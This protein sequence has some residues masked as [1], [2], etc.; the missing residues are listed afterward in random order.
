MSRKLFSTVTLK[1]F[2]LAFMLAL[3]WQVNSQGVKTT[4]PSMAPVNQYLMPDKNSE[5]ALAA[6]AAPDSI[7]RDAEVLVLTQHGYETAV[8]GT[9]GFG[10]SR[11]CGWTAPLDLPNV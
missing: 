6:S 9:N 1:I 5:I 7:S 3:A 11:E 4:Y 10:V 8:K 2:A